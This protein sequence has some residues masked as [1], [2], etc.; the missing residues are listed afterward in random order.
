MSIRKRLTLILLSMMVLTCFLALVKG[1][2]KSMH[3]GENLLDNELKIVAGV[4]IEQPLA[5]ST[6]AVQ[7]S[8]NSAQLLYQIW[9]N[10]SLLSGS[11]S[12]TNNQIS[13]SEGFQTANVAG[14]RMRVFVMSKN[15][16]KVIIAEPIAK[17]FELAE[18]V[19]LSAMLPMLWAVPLLAIFISFFVKYALAPLT[20]LSKQL[21]SRQANDFTPINWQVTDEE[22]KPVINRLNDLF[23]RVE[24]AYL[25][26]RFFASDAA[27][28]LR[29]PLS[30]LKINVHNL[31]NKQ[32]NSQNNQE[33]QAMSQGI[34]RLS[35]IVEQ[36]LILGRTQPEQWQK[37]FSEQSLLTITQQA[38][39]EQY[40]KIDEKNQTISLEG[41]DFVIN[42]DEFTLTTLI[43]NL[44]SNAIK[45]TP[46]NGQIII[47]LASSNN[48]YSWQIDDSGAGM[49]DEQ[50]DRIF[51]RFYRVGGDQHP[52]GEQGAGLGM[53][54]VQHIIAI[55]DA[56]IHLANSSLGGLTVKVTFTGVKSD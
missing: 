43:A 46:S 36:M 25:R 3:H 33:L 38:V 21:A 42:G 54:I 19:I 24:T 48:D 14:Q 18:A 15:T 49:T 29:T 30:S 26:E 1:Y 6:N 4:L 39:S 9:Q 31:A 35:N 47:K 23:K 51:N 12:L 28:E 53:A 13:F 7:V 22:I 32:S 20:R 56:K 40:D 5:L 50:K 44:L 16:R 8:N 34:N 27:H 37:Q 10:N 45:Y 11:S 52:S 55:Y 2:Q 17:R 41:D